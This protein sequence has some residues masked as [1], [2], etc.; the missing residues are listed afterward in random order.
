MWLLRML[1]PLV[2]FYLQASLLNLPILIKLNSRKERLLTT[3]GTRASFTCTIS[4][5]L[6]ITSTFISVNIASSAN[7]LYSLEL[8]LH[9]CSS[10]VYITGSFPLTWRLVT[11]AF[12]TKSNLPSVQVDL[13]SSQ[14]MLFIGLVYS[15]ISISLLDRWFLLHCLNNPLNPPIIGNLH[16]LKRVCLW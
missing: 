11:Q 1:E 8:I 15:D 13:P 3:S 2:T 4:K 16:E 7:R 9:Q 14:N 10:R 5:H 6:G 12:S